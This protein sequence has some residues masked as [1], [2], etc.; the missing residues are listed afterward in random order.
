MFNAEFS[1]ANWIIMSTEEM[2]FLLKMTGT[3]NKERT[4]KEFWV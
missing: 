1:K 4:Y 3:L 2:Q